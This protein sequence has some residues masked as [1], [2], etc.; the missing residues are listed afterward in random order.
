MIDIVTF[1]NIMA[2][3]E[4]YAKYPEIVKISEDLKREVFDK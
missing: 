2:I 4:R 1:E 3:V